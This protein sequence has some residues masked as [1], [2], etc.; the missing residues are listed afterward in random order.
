MKKIIQKL[1]ETRVISVALAL[2]AMLFGSGNI[3]F[4]LILGSQSG[5]NALYAMAGFFLTAV[6]VPLIGIIA[7]AL[8]DGD[9]RLFLGRIG[10]IPSFFLILLCLALI[11]PFCI[12]PRS[13]ALSHKALQWFIPGL[14][15]PLFSILAAILLYICTVRQ[16]RVV[17]I[18]GKFLGPIKLTLLSIVILKGFF[19]PALSS[20]C[21]IP[22][23]DIFVRGL[24]DGYGTLDLLA[25]IFFSSLILGMLHSPINGR[26][27]DKKEVILTACKAGVLGASLLGFVYAGFVFVASW[28]MNACLAVAPEQLLSSLASVLLGA[29]GGVLASIT[30]AVACLTTA[31][32]LTTVFANYLSKEL[33]PQFLTYHRALF[34]TLGTTLIFA[35][36]GFAKI[37]SIV[38]PIIIVCYPALIV[39]S[40]TN[41][42]YKLWDIDLGPIPFY[43]ALFVS[44]VLQIAPLLV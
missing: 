40:L 30:L 32:A 35:N 5:Q 42:V 23:W 22:A 8:F 27:P 34:V 39:L 15:L 33:F 3:V 20:V 12:I 18:L 43:G 16:S 41:I 19:V 11:G 44:A 29:G 1:S 25:S 37:M 24:I 26:I 36:L 4:P 9:Y 10:K 2:F 14:S 28:Q 31:I 38:A 6:I 7:M 17:D 13:V 21:E